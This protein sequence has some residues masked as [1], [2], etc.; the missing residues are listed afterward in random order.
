MTLDRDKAFDELV[1]RANEWMENPPSFGRGLKYFLRGFLNP[2]GFKSN[3]MGHPI[4]DND[5]LTP[6]QKDAIMIA[7]DVRRT[8]RYIEEVESEEKKAV[9]RAAQENLYNIYKSMF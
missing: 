9:L 5:E 8:E 4:Y 3:G 7:S 6:Q 1:D 2:F